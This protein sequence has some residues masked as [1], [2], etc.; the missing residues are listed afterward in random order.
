MAHTDNNYIIYILDLFQCLSY[1]VN[2]HIKRDNLLSLSTINGNTYLIQA[3]SRAAR[4]EWINTIHH[5]KQLYTYTEHFPYMVNS[6]CSEY[7]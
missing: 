4:E 6:C 3:D 7:M 1:P 2:D 5:G